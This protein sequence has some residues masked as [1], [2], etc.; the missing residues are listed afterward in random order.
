M[1]EYQKTI[2]ELE[3]ELATSATN[4][5]SESSCK[6]RIS[7]YG[8][9]ELKEEDKESLLIKFLKEFTDPL[10]VILLIA[11]VV[12][13]IVDPSEWIESVIILVVVLINAI[14]GVYQENNAEKSLEALKKL[15]S[16]NAKVIRDG[17]KKTIPSEEV[18]VGDLIVI[19]AGD[20][21]AS[22][23]R[24]VSSMRMQVDESALTGESVPV[25]KTAEIIDK[26]E[27]ALGDMKNM[28]FASTMCTYGRGLAIVTS[29]GM[30]N[31]VGKI[32]DMLANKEEGTTP[33]QMKLT[34]ISKTIGI[35]C[36]AI[37]A[38]VFILEMMTGME[39]L[40][41][42]KTAVALAVAAIPEGLATVVTIVL[43]IGVSKM[44]RYN[45]IVRKLPAVETLGCCSVICS[46][47][48]GTLTQNKMTITKTYT[49]GSS[50]KQFTIKADDKTKEMLSYFTLCSDG[51]I[52]EVDGAFK[53]IGDP[54]E[55]AFVYASYLL[56]DIKK[57]LNAKYRRIEE[58]A[59]DADRKLMTVF[60]K[61]DDGILQITKGAPDVVFDRC[62][63]TDLLEAKRINEEM[64]N[65]ALRVLAVAIKKLDSVDD[66]PSSEVYEKDLSFVGLAGMI[67]PPRDE[68]KEAIA[69]AKIG[70][71]KT[72]MITG[73]HLNTAKAIAKDLAIMEEGDMAING[74][75]L[76]KMSDEDL[77]DKIE[78]IKVYARVAP[79]H[80]VR[81]V[82]AF[83]KRG[84][85]VAMTGDGV[86]DSPALKTADIGCAM[87]ITGTDVSKSASDMVLT[88]DN[89]A[90]IISAVKQGRGIYSNI[91]K[92]VHFLLSCNIG[93]VITIFGAS[94]VQVLFGIPLGTPLLPIHILWVNLITDTLPA[95]AIG[96]EPVDPDV[97]YQKPRP[98]NESFFA[99][100]MGFKVTYQGVIVGLLTLASYMIGNN[101]SHEIGMTMAF[102]TLV[103]VQL[104]HSFNVKS[105]KSV[106]NKQVF[107]NKYLWGATIVGI[108][109]L[110]VI[111]YVPF[112]NDIFELAALDLYH[113]VVAVGL[114]LVMLVVMEIVKAF[115]RV[116]NTSKQ[117][118]KSVQS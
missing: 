87:G 103:L 3:E 62:V 111:T 44:V 55:T 86:N 47:K 110:L 13:V 2:E 56:G 12:S 38:V 69:Q 76:D 102:I 63:D 85:V 93:E 17:I 26:D 79:E 95:F 88:D 90:T 49:K 70:G 39:I 4:G 82:S 91:K 66:N 19:E 81:I 54:T 20:Y 84:E 115:R 109:L 112:L 28:V 67:D 83:Q 6:E 61:T 57:D 23:A 45:A 64:T 14:L 77:A 105:E 29:V 117:S 30:D 9:N 89:F 106:F 80:K 116:K 101:D 98:K 8:K 32:A 7:R 104:I 65:E 51:D 41:A 118:M 18:C 15:S 50:L 53:S 33:L 96:M 5:I 100:G 46:D 22:D 97:I 21:I 58:I 114:A 52:E 73:D 94:L 42:F 75:D 68:V 1:K 107:N 40:D 108:V 11:A 31:E 72:V 59:F 60:L 71:I 74:A 25:N 92:D 99:G 78:D 27:L 10:I 34:Q 16:P 48:T 43:S 37:C 113:C 36:L 35:M 24:I